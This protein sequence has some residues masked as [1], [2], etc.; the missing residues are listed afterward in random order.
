MF[1]A[2]SAVAT[3]N[4]VASD[5][6]TTGTIGV[7]PVAGYEPERSQ[8]GAQMRNGGVE[9]RARLIGT[10]QL[11]EAPPVRRARLPAEAPNRR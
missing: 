5:P 4:A 2:S 7:S 8:T 6:S 1:L 11:H 10:A 3:C 9:T